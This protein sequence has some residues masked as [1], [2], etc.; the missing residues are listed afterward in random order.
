M[1]MWWLWDGALTYDPDFLRVDSTAT[2]AVTVTGTA[3]AGQDV[4]L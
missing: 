3:E 4:D 1:F 2:A